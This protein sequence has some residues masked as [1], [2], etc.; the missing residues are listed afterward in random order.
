MAEKSWSRRDVFVHI[1]FYPVTKAGCRGSH[2]MVFFN[3]TW[4]Q[5]PAGPSTKVFK[6]TGEPVMLAV[7]PLSQFRWSRHWSCAPVE[8][9]RKRTRDITVR[10]GAKRSRGRRPRSHGLSDL[11]PYRSGWTRCD[12]NIDW[13]GWRS[14]GLYMLTSDLT[15]LVPLQFNHNWLQVRKVGTVFFFFFSRVLLT[16]MFPK[17][18]GF[19]NM[20]E[21]AIKKIFP[22]VIPLNLHLNFGKII[23]K[24]L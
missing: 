13:S 3:Q 9:G 16:E 7:K 4:V 12:Q 15:S 20:M 23:L 17:I 8:R 22:F 5:T 19:I 18:F 21:R 11:C 10:N 2:A 24:P 6:K 14:A 1:L